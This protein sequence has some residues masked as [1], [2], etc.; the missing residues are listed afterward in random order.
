MTAEW[1][2]VVA[3]DPNSAMAKSVATHLK[4]AQTPVPSASAAPGAR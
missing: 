2:K 3:I 1:K 4:S